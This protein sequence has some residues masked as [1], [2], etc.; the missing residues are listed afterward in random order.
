MAVQIPLFVSRPRPWINSISC[1][2]DRPDP[3]KLEPVVGSQQ[4]TDGTINFFPCFGLYERLVDLE[5][6][7]CSVQGGELL[8]LLLECTVLFTELRLPRDTVESCLSR[9][10]KEI[11]QFSSH[12][13]EGTDLS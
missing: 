1:R 3:G 2:I 6:S 10:G 7:H 4:L 13:V 5:S 8:V 12:I 11:G 9:R